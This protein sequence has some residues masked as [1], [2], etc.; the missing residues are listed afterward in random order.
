MGEVQGRERDW[1]LVSVLFITYRRFD[2]LKRSMEAFRKNTSYPNLEMVIADDGSPFEVQERIRGLAADVFALSPKNRGLGAN[3]NHGLRHCSGKYI[4][5]IQ[6]DCMCYGPSDYLLN[7][8]LVM[9]ANPRIGIVNYCGAPHPLEKENRVG[10]SNEPCFLNARLYEDH[11]KEYFFYTDQPHVISRA[12]FEHIGFY[13]ESGDLEQ[14]EEDYNRR[15]RDQGTFAT[16]VFPRYYQDTFRHEGAD[17]SFR[18]TRLRYR[19][20]A[21][22]QPVKCFVPARLVGLA[23]KAVMTPVYLLERMGVI[24]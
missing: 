24:R 9:E 19:I 23:R 10:G 17:V 14:C 4:L 11:K 6:D 16:A 22:L 12:A 7:T 18:T 13:M 21:R 15:W 5:M 3:N 2:K 8:I 1:P 20:A